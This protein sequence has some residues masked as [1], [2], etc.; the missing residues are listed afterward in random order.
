MSVSTVRVAC[1]IK[2]AE[3]SERV[4][5]VIR[6]EGVE[7]IQ[8]PHA[9]LTA[10]TATW[11]VWWA[12]VYDLAPWDA[13]ALRVMRRISTLQRFAPT[14]LYVPNTPD[15]VRV[16]DDCVAEYP[17]LAQ[18]QGGNAAEADR[19]RAEV[20][21]LLDRIPGAVV[22]ELV[23]SIMRNPGGRLE[24]FV[25]TAMTDLVLHGGQP[26]PTV[27]SVAQAMRSTVRTVE[28]TLHELG[29]PPPNELLGWITLLYVVW[30]AV[31]ALKPV[32]AF[33][34]QLGFHAG[35]VH[36]LRHRLQPTEV[37]RVLDDG[38]VIPDQ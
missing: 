22:A 15:A 30:S 20:R 23:L 31:R 11:P 38:D 16:L 24:L 5:S 6:S 17:V 25:R 2:D 19:L 27:S 8:L 21:E 9:T 4:A 12:L 3:V 26:Q 28:H 7:L 10:E 32:D 13:A 18:L 29:L 1:S 37:S 33:A 36:R 34:R 35:A 14:L